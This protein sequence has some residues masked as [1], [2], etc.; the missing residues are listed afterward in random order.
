[1]AA[2]SSVT[3]GE[4]SS[5]GTGAEDRLVSPTALELPGRV[6]EVASSNST[7]YAL[8]ADGSVYAWGLGITPAS[9]AMAAPETP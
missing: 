2:G 5:Q 7:Q 3:P 8:L 1:M 9:W 6:V 4:R